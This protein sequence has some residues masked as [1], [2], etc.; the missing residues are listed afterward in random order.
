MD[1]RDGASHPGQQHEQAPRP[2]PGRSEDALGDRVHL[3]EVVHQP[4]VGAERG[5]RVRERGEVEAVEQ[6]GRHQ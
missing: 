2:H 1:H 3:A 5:E 6:R 4:A